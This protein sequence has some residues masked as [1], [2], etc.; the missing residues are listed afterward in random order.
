[1]LLTGTQVAQYSWLQIILMWSKSIKKRKWC[2]PLDKRQ[3][4]NPSLYIDSRPTVSSENESYLEGASEKSLKS[5][6][7]ITA[8]YSGNSWVL[9]GGK[10]PHKQ[11]QDFNWQGR[12]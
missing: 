8:F 4:S 2:H 3:F 5:W 9:L 10:I 7:D 1:M 6:K 11:S 12:K